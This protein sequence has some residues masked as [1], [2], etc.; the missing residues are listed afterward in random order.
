M[1]QTKPAEVAVDSLRLGGL[2]R[3]HAEV[4]AQREI[5]PILVHR[6]TLRVVDGMHRLQASRLRGEKVIPVRYLDGPVSEVFI[7]SVAANVSHGLPLTLKDR[8]AAAE[9]ILASHPDLSDRAIA[10]IT[11]LSPKS[12]GTVRRASTE[13]VPHSEVRVGAD[14]RSRP[15]D[16]VRRREA[17]RAFL[18]EHP[19][20]TLSEVATSPGCRSGMAAV[21]QHPGGPGH[22]RHTVEQ[23][24]AQGSGHSEQWW[25]RVLGDGKDPP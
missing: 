21:R 15:L 17:A 14:G 20:A 6:D 11:G 12:V 8:K 5:E 13:E 25:G 24:S 1:K 22:R 7:H 23:Q 3:E 19:D 9:R 4:L 10:R 16:A 2:S 18:A